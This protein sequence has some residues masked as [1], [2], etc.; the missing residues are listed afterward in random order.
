MPFASVLK[1]FKTTKRRA[2]SS[3]NSSMV[4]SDD[5]SSELLSNQSIIAK[6]SMALPIMMRD[7]NVMK[8]GIIKLVKLAGGTQRDKADRFFLKSSE[9]ET[10][11]ETQ[12]S[13][14]KSNKSNSPTK[15]GEKKDGKG[16]FG[17]AND[18][19]NAIIAGGITNMLI[20]GGLIAGILYAIGK[21]FTSS[22]FRTGVFDMIGKFGATVFGEEGWK[23]VKKNIVYGSVILLAG[24]VAIK[25]SLALV[26]SG[27]TALAAKLFGIGGVPMVPGGP[28]NKSKSP[29][30]KI[31][32]GL[33]MAGIGMGLY[34][35]IAGDD[36]SGLGSAGSAAAGVASSIGLDYL[37]SP[38]GTPTTTTPTETS[39]TPQSKG[40]LKGTKKTFLVFLEK[41]APDLFKRIGK[42]LLAAGAGLFVPGPGWFMTALSIVGTFSLAWQLYQWWK[43]FNGESGDTSSN[44]PEKI[45]NIEKEQSLEEWLGGLTNQTPISMMG[46]D[47]KVSGTTNSPSPSSST[48][49]NS[50][51]RSSTGSGSVG[52]VL[53]AIKGV[54][55][56]GNYNAKNPNSSASGAYQFIDSTWR[57]S[58]KK[59][60]IGEE[61]KTARDAPPHI[62]DEV[63]KRS[64]EDLLNKYNGD[65]DKVLNVWYTGNPNGN[66]TAVQLAANKGQTA[67]GY[68]NKFKNTSNNTGGNLN[69][70]SQQLFNS[71]SSASAPV[72]INAPT[73]NN[74][75][76]GN[77]G[78]TI[79]LPASGVV[80]L[81]LT[82]LLVERAIG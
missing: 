74:N 39:K 2:K 51:Q 63:A 20:K 32:R 50:P 45:N 62:Q 34:N 70:T 27:L 65:V 28:T 36:A 6:N 5:T 23:D 59:Y 82:K 79:N 38:R 19:L 13:A 80:D 60:G 11:Y 75:G 43:E 18:F 35:L 25:T 15:V 49:F 24:I 7:I 64:V 22:E 67:E 9:R 3:S 68:R 69:S 76:G 53:S 72:V 12:M 52:E 10:A 61:F 1:Q 57:N 55:S 77:A 66:M 4:N 41:R 48:S 8:Q 40:T 54:E 78:G 16:F 21:F 73:T 37:S 17:N 14:N 33:G 29:V 71:R 42:R 44:S 26:T 58:T 56:S 47:S 46:F 30:G 31:F 81:E